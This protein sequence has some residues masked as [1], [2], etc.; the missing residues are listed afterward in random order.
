MDPVDQVAYGCY[1]GDGVHGSYFVEVDLVDGL[2]VGVAFCL[3]DEGVDLF[4][5]VDYLGWKVQVVEGV[6]DGG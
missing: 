4:G 6:G 1:V 5:V 2:S 3:G